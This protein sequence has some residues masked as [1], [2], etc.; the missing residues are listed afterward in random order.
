[1]NSYNLKNNIVL[2]IMIIF[3]TD[4]ITNI[5]IKKLDLYTLSNLFS[6][7][8]K[9]FQA[10][11]KYN[12]YNRHFKLFYQN[13]VYHEYVGLIHPDI[14]NLCSKFLDKCKGI[15]IN[16]SI[17]DIYRDNNIYQYSNYVIVKTV[18]DGHQNYFLTIRILNHILDKYDYILVNRVNTENY[19]FAY[20]PDN[21]L[22]LTNE[23]IKNHTYTCGCSKIY[24]C[25]NNN[26][27]T[28]SKNILETV[29]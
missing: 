1:M 19:S 13:M 9:I 27:D 2:D 6:T 24:T 14:K 12:I 18:L 15:T 11:R 28:I 8:K 22:H 4:D 17:Y 16:Q 5:L 26:L 7:S 29:G 3:N 23:S 20:N 10:L 21:I 25:K